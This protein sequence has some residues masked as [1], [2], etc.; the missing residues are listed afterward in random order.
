MLAFKMRDMKFMEL[1]GFSWG[2]FKKYFNQKR[3]KHELFNQ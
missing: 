2:C 3:W 1:M